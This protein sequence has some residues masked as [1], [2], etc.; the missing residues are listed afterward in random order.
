MQKLLNELNLVVVDTYG[1]KIDFK[2]YDIVDFT[3]VERTDIFYKNKW[4]PISAEKNLLEVLKK[5]YGVFYNN[6]VYY[7]VNLAP[8]IINKEKVNLENHISKMLYERKIDKYGI[9]KYLTSPEH[10][11]F[12]N[13]AMLLYEKDFDIK[14][15]K[16]K[17]SGKVKDVDAFIAYLEARKERAVS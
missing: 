9:Q 14:F 17:L 2:K 6:K 16:R 3:G 5:G 1:F 12:V 11:L 8:E 10:E 7:S 13:N 4:V 15:I